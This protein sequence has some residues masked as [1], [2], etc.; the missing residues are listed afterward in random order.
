MNAAGNNVW[1]EETPSMLLTYNANLN[2]IT[3]TRKADKKVVRFDNV[4]DM[5]IGEYEAFVAKH[6]PNNKSYKNCLTN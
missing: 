2:F 1:T 4:E 5:T 3:I 6:L